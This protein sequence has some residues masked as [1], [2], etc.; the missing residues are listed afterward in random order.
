MTVTSITRNVLGKPL[1]LCCDDPITG[2]Y[3]DG[4]CHTNKDDVGSHVVCASMTNELLQFSLNL[5]NDLI[6]PHPDLNFSGL[7]SGNCWCLCVLRWQ[8][9]YEAGVAPPIKLEA[10]HEKALKYL[11]LDILL[12]YAIA[13]K[14]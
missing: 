5:G 3:R 7:K 13:N 4:F 11:P 1:E 12:K 2:F 14:Q 6:T 10:T 8:E 9:A